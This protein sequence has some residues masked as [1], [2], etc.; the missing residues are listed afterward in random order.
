MYLGVEYFTLGLT[1]PFHKVQLLVASVSDKL[2]QFSRTEELQTLEERRTFRPGSCL[3]PIVFLPVAT[4]T[5]LFLY[6]LVYSYTGLFMKAYGGS[7]TRCLRLKTS[8]FGMWGFLTRLI[9]DSKRR[10]EVVIPLPASVMI[11]PFHSGVD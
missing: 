5:W 10:G 4:F 8:V 1:L 11:A 6:L 7:V 9:V 2:Y 3:I